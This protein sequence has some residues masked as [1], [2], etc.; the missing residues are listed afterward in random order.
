MNKQQTLG[1]IRHILTVA[2]GF[3]VAKGIG[4]EGLF[5]EITG[6]LLVVIGGSWSLIAPEK[7]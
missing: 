2:G 5:E 6:A 1:L 3:A 7:Q 4:S